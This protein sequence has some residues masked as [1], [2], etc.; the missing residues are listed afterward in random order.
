LLA[1]NFRALEEPAK[2]GKTWIITIA[3]LLLLMASFFVPALDSIPP[4]VYSLGF[5]LAANFLAKK[6]QG[7][8]IELHRVNGGKMFST[9]WAVLAG[10]VSM[11]L[12]LAL[13]FGI[14]YLQDPLAGL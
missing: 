12:L 5:C 13:F 4:F 6:Y 7:S 2:A 1:Q 11:L 8:S 14:V 10:V 9:W 3:I